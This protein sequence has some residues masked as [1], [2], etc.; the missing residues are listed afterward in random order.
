MT[1]GLKEETESLYQSRTLKLKNVSKQAFSIQVSVS[2]R[3]SAENLVKAATEFWSV[4]P[5][6][7][8][9]LDVS[10]L[11]G[12]SP[13]HLNRFKPE[14]LPLRERDE[15]KMDWPQCPLL[16]LPP[17]G[18]N[19][20]AQRMLRHPMNLHGRVVRKEIGIGL[21]QGGCD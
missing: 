8:C 4:D 1:N 15:S 14:E 6:Q 5:V 20:R 19:D 3:I 16:P 2:P 10:H 13:F 12:S 7:E 21:H 11:Y 9:P 18:D 17:D